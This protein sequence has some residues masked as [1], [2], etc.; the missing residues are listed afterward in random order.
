MSETIEFHFKKAEESS[1]FLLWQLTM[2]WQRK[3]KKEL[4]KLDITHTQFVLMA[5][6]AWLSKTNSNISQ[7]EIA[8]HSKTDRMM[9]SKVLR[10]LIDKN[11]IERKEHPNDTRAK[12]IKLSTKGAS[13]LQ[14]ALVIVEKTDL[15]FFSKLGKDLAKMNENM[16]TLLNENVD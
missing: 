9:V 15:Q 11:M 14:K 2:L 5:S 16:L 3:I 1:G 10:T 13:I 8:N 12:T 4:D 6:I 7:V